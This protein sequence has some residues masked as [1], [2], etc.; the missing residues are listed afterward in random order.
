[1]KR[2][3][4]LVLAALPAL[5]SAA[6]P[7]FLRSDRG[8][9]PAQTKQLAQGIQAELADLGRKEEAERAR[10]VRATAAIGSMLA[11][12][13]HHGAT[14]AKPSAV[15][16]LVAEFQ[17]ISEGHHKISDPLVF[18]IAVYARQL[19]KYRDGGELALEES[20]VAEIKDTLT[21][22]RTAI[23]EAKP[24]P[25]D[26]RE[27]RRYLDAWWGPVPQREQKQQL[28]PTKTPPPRAAPS[29]SGPALV[30]DAGRGRPRI[31]PVPALIEQLASADPRQRALAADA[32][33]A[34]G[35]AALPAVTPLQQ[36]LHDQDGRVRASAVLSLAAVAGASPGVVEA[37][38]SAL[39]DKD[40][41]VRFSAGA[42]LQS[43]G[44]PR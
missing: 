19:Q 12:L 7:A 36:A 33:G 9:S 21:H 34:R 8:L 18:K 1:V 3:A 38:R 29:L 24:L 15:D 27:L 5:A 17:R 31:D 11:M 26:I 30:R 6:D 32:L 28:P 23:A 22:P 4:L 39:K 35:E 44:R 16:D 14:G 13:D 10:Y 37:I 40:A 43:L 42:A 41:D 20:E 2:L 25:L